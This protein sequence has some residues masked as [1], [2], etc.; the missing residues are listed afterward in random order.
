[1]KTFKISAAIALV[2]FLIGTFLFLLQLVTTDM[3]T[4]P[5]ISFYYLLIALFFNAIVLLTLIGK[6]FIDSNYSE[7]LKSIAIILVNIPIAIF[8]TYIIFKYTSI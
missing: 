8:Y 6:L 1:M 3:L 2:F 4:L 7:I 5:I